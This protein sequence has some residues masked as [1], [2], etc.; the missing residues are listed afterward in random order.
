MRYALSVA[1]LA[2]GAFAAPVYVTD[3]EVITTVDVIT[4]TATGYA[5]A[6][7]ASPT[8]SLRVAQHVA[9]GDHH[10]PS[11]YSESTTTA[12][13]T[14]TEAA[15]PVYVAPTTS[16]EAST[17]TSIYVAPT[18]SSEEQVWAAPTTEAYVAPT[19]PAVW[20]VPTSIAAP[21]FS[22]PAATQPATG[23]I[24]TD[25]AG[26]A[27]Y[28][29]NQH[30]ANH[31]VPDVQWS[32]DLASAAQVVASSCVFNHT[33]GVNGL[34]YGQNIAGTWNTDIA[35]IIAGEW[36]SEASA[37]GSFYG[38]TNPPDSPDTGH[39]TQ[40]VWKDTTDI[41]CATQDCRGVPGLDNYFVVCN[42]ATAGNFGGKF[43]T[44]VLPPL[45]HSPAS[46]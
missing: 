26:R 36:Y 39:F 31:S 12:E 6:A 28:Q 4:I 46:Y 14:T 1:A 29:H 45:G 40:L 10:A 33:M 43:N 35:A 15:A 3:Y 21:V 5:P 19:V 41:G 7:T 38:L 8:E 22:A 30:R 20:S 32:A 34:N 37:Y 17:F 2:A 11:E 24:P 42:Y 23:A 44:Q 13:A 9:Q 18:S 16:A 27:V 25:Y